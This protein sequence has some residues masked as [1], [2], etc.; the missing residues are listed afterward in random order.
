MHLKGCEPVWF[1]LDMMI[2]TMELY[3]LVLVLVILSLIQ[4]QRDAE[5]KKLLHQLFHKVTN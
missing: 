1:K 4:G 2:D 5:K 3:I